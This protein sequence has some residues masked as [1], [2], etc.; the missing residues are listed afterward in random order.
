MAVVFGVVGSLLAVAGAALA[1][2]AV[3]SY[4]RASRLGTAA[5]RT[6][7]LKRGFRK[8]RGRVAP[9]GGPLRG[10]MTGQEC[11]HYR[12]RVDEEKRE[13]KRSGGLSTPS[14]GAMLAGLFGGGLGRLFYTTYGGD[15]DEGGPSKVIH[16]WD[17]VLDD[18]GG[19]RLLVEDATGAVEVDLQGADVVTKARTLVHADLLRP[20]DPTLQD[21]LRKRYRIHTVDERG[22]VKSMRLTE[23]ILKQGAKVTVLGAVESDPDG[24]LSF[25]RGGPNGRLLVTEL[26]VE[27]GARSDRAQGTVFAAVAAGALLLAATFAALAF[28]AVAGGR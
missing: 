1:V 18:A 24:G 15:R 10:P 23:E 26:D 16:S 28:A 5:S 6:G 19:V 2:F 7:K 4:R 21:L 8:V 3:R 12:L 27:K 9:A 11:V 20:L 17:N 25:R 22:R 13:W 14:S